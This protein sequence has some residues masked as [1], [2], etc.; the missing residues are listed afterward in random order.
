MKVLSEGRQN[1]LSHQIT[2]QLCETDF[3]DK[4]HKEEIF[5]KVKQAFYFFDKETKELDRLISEKILSIKRGVLPGSQEWDILYT[6][7]YEEEFRKKSKLL[8]TK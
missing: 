5:D 4:S 1:Y 7:F 2:N 8:L 6:R 3:V